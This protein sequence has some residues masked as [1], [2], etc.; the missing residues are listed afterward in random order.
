MSL[1]SDATVYASIGRLRTA[2]IPVDQVEESRMLREAASR[3]KFEIEV[4][5][6][7]GPGGSQ[8]LHILDSMTPDQLDLL[9]CAGLIYHNEKQI[10]EVA[11]M[12]KDAIGIS[13]FAFYDPDG[14]KVFAYETFIDYFV[15]KPPDFIS[16][17][18]GWAIGT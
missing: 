8:G 13:R 5:G 17:G 12:P 9:I 3:E 6:V 16:T 10:T 1:E 11:G 4:D 15:E 18:R 14:E 7:L 2:G